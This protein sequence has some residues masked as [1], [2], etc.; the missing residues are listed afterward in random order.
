MDQLRTSR[1]DT[2]D[3]AVTGATTEF[4]ADVLDLLVRSLRRAAGA[5]LPDV[6]TDTLLEALVSG[7]T[8]AGAAIAP[9]MRRAGALGGRIKAMAGRGWVSDDEVDAVPGDASLDAAAGDCAGTHQEP[10]EF[11]VDAVWREARWRCESGAR[12]PDTEKGRALPGTTGAVRACLLRA[13]RAARAEGTVSVR[14]RHVARALLDVPGTRAQEALLLER[15]DRAAASAALD[16]LDASAPAE[17]EASYSVGVTLLRRTGTLGKSG[18]FLSRRLASWAYGTALNGS[19]VLAAVSTEAMRQAVR[20]GRAAAE[21]V[22]LVLGM[23]SLDRALAVAGCALPAD[24]ADANAASALLY[25]HGARQS[26]LVRAARAVP[27]AAVFGADTFRL[28]AA[29]DRA[30]AVARLTAA[31]H[32]SPT[33]GT[34][35]LLAALLDEAAV[36]DTDTGQDVARLLA[37]EGVDVAALRAEL[38]RRSGA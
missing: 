9:G 14:C 28:S 10:D 35:H 29:A 2:D 23:L 12:G 38:S 37:A 1:A 36:T 32:G 30:M 20:G 16:R 13:L 19:P 31:E 11:E 4:E 24:L 27:P 34:N 7:D 25:R 8:G 5:E 18:N 15:L 3:T 17:E 21:P 6:G 26:S 22:D 33:T